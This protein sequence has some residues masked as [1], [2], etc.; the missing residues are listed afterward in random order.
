MSQMAQSRHFDHAPLASGLHRWSQPV[1]ATLYLEGE[2]ECGLTGHRFHRGFTAAEKTELWDRW[3]RGES[4]KAKNDP[5]RRKDALDARGRRT[6]S[7]AQALSGTSVA[8]MAEQ[9]KRSKA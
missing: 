7:S 4:L 2:M 5:R 8:A 6:P 3:K 1:D 9:M